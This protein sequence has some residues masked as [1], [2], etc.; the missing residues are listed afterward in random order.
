MNRG[1]IPRKKSFSDN[2][3]KTASKFKKPEEKLRLNR[4][5]ANAG[6]C[7]RREADKLITAGE[8]KVNGK[9]VTEMGMKVG[10]K[11]KVQYKGKFISPEKSVYILLNKPGGFITSMK[12]E[13]G[14]KTV[15]DLVKK[16]CNERIYPVGRLDRATTGL[17]LFTNDGEFAQKL[18]HPSKSVPKIYEVT[19]NRPI[20]GEDFESIG[21]GTMLED[22]M[23]EVD[24]LA[25]VSNDKHSV[26]VKIHSGKNRIVRRLF[27]H[28]GYTVVRLD[29]VMYAGLD[30]KGISRGNWRKLTEKEVIRL[31]Y[32]Q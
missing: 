29:R 20:E 26:G 32:F 11:D 23:A 4:Y 12:D 31:K 13:R 17:L 3:P 27:E 8:I 9:I 28:Y 10:T 19:L 6:I 22:G 15:M 24:D 7:S 16:A 21:K 5:I 30:K 14:R 18:S 25:I 1:K 2:K